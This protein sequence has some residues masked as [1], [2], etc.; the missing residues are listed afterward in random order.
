MVAAPS[1]V[2]VATADDIPRAETLAA[3]LALPLLLQPNNMLSSSSNTLSTPGNVLPR[4]CIAYLS[5]RD[6]RLQLFPAD[7]KQSGPICVDFASNAAAF[8]LQSGGELIVKAV[9]GR[10]KNPLCV[11]DA[12]A[13]LGRDSFVLAANGF[14]VTLLERNAIVAALLHDGLQRAKQSSAA[15]IVARMEL[16]RSDALEYFVGLSDEQVAGVEQPDVIYLDPMFAHSE[17][18]ALVKKDMRLFRQLLGAEHS[19][20][21]ALFD[22]ARANAKLRVVVKRALKAPNFAGREPGYTLAGKAIR[23]DVYP[24]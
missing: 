24:C 16:I 15:E 9:R 18:T 10:S 19:D 8:R 23:Y 17:K 21:V 20:E 12:T 5:Y 4:E 14:D 3:Q 7:T 2:V 1:V 6:D 11:L 13:G 22:C